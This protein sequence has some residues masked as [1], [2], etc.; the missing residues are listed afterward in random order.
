LATI[1][2]HGTQSAVIRDQIATLLSERKLRCIATYSALAN[3]PQL[4]ELVSEL[5]HFRWTLPR[6][7][8][9]QLVFHQVDHP[10]QLKPGAFGIAEPPSDLEVVAVH[11]IDLILCPGLGFDRHGVRLGKGKGHYDRALA[12]ARPDTLSAGIAF[13]Q[14]L[15]DELPSEPHDRPMNLVISGA[16]TT[17]WPLQSGS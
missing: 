17:I 2:D 7:N 1:D 6:V 3:E 14:Q 15:A 13:Y 12:N 16:G 8:G 5:P 10:D 11:D 9:E 4:L